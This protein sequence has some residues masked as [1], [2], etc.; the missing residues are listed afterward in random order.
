MA[1]I[2]VESL[3]QPVSDDQ[4]SGEDLE[5]DPLF[6]EMEQAMAGKPEQTMGSSVIEA[7]EP[8]WKLAQKNALALLERTKDLRVCTSLAQ[9]MLRNGGLEGLSEALSLTRSLTEQFW[10]SIYPELDEED[11]FDPTARVN[12]IITLTTPASMLRPI[13][14]APL[15]SVP[16]LGSVCW[17]DV[18]P[19]ADQ[20]TAETSSEAQAIINHCELEQIQTQRD[21]VQLC[22]DSCKGIE[23]FVTEQVGASQAPSLEGLRDLLGKIYNQLDRWWA[24][25]GGDQSAEEEIATDDDSDSNEGSISGDP[26]SHSVGRTGGAAPVGA[27]SAP[28][29][30]SSRDDVIAAIDRILKY[31]QQYEPSSPLPLL[32]MRA[33]RLA[34]KSFIEIL[35]DLIPEGLERAHEIGGL[36]PETVGE[37]T[38]DDAGPITESVFSNDDSSESGE[39]TDDDFFS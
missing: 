2:D 13:E 31:Y 5:Y 25:R 37:M 23:Q 1:L 38:S 7:E 21:A 29:V 28:G 30:I 33:K 20:E 32:L 19:E 27:G 35:Q 26:S 24:E 14:D 16:M 36:K 8:D 18:K 39:D 22:V 9:A 34:T 4:P 15:L 3:Q 17:A 6:L 11:D 12:A 10:P